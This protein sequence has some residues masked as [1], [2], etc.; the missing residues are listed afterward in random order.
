MLFKWKD[1]RC[2]RSCFN[3][4][5]F[6]MKAFLFLTKKLQRIFS[7]SYSQCYFDLQIQGGVCVC[8]C[9]MF[10]HLVC[11][12]VSVLK[13]YFKY[14]RLEISNGQWFL[15]LLIQDVWFINRTFFSSF[16]LWGRG[17]IYLNIIYR[18][19]TVIYTLK[20]RKD[21]GRGL[22]FMHKEQNLLKGIF[23]IPSFS[24]QVALN[25]K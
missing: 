9:V 25:K 6:N 1:L 13:G 11:V 14:L 24:P 5:N 12:Y 16:M 19:N 18:K 21:Y 15:Q 23:L 2:G 7:V 10:I 22:R 17:I 3:W 4:P 20:K 8:M